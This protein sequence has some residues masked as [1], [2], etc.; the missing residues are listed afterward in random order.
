M[1]LTTDWATR[2]VAY[3]L[4]PDQLRAPRVRR[5]DD[6]RPDPLVRTG[7]AERADYRRSG[8]T[9]GHLVPAG[10]MTFSAEAMSE[11]F[12]YSNVSPQLAEHNGAVWREL[13]ETARDW[14]R[15]KGP[16]YVTTGPVVE[17]GAEVIGSNR[18]AVPSAYYKV[19]LTEDGEGI[20]FLI[21]HDRQTLPLTAFAKTIDEIE[22]ATG[23][24]FFPE[25]DSLA[26]EAIEARVDPSAWPL[27]EARYRRRLTSW[28]NTH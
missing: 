22:A 2:W 16:T 5:S 28:N 11:T 8:F 1:C 21:P 27:D 9:R 18:V 13:E 19:L 23:L 20:G 26:T 12:F 10:D 17:R 15:A 6:F 4:T 14:I 3:R 7:S 25:L 24:D